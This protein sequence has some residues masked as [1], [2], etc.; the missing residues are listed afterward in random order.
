MRLFT[1]R[2]QKAAVVILQQVLITLSVGRHTMAYLFNVQPV[3]SW[4]FLETPYRLIIKKIG[5]HVPAHGRR[6]QNLL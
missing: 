6:Y 1:A 3:R 4:R 2:Y 5:H